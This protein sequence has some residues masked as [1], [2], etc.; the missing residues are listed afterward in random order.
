[1]KEEKIIKFGRLCY[2][3][4]F[5]SSG[6]STC[7]KYES[8]KDGYILYHCRRLFWRFYLIIDEIL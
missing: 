5:D 6:N 7:E 4:L 1:M 8:F 3:K 2:L